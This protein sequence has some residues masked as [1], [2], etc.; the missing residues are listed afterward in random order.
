MFVSRDVMEIDFRPATWRA[1]L[2]FLSNGLKYLYRRKAAQGCD[3]SLQLPRE[4]T[5]LS[6]L[7]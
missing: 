3:T 5:L 2:S 4:A 1:R 7:L 6:Y